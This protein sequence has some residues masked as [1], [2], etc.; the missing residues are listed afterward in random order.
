LL[1]LSSAAADTRIDAVAVSGY[2]QSREEVW[3]EPIYRNVWALLHEFGDA[4]L[5]GLVAP[6]ALVVEAARG[7]E[8]PDPP[9]ATGSVRDGRLV[10]AARGRL[11][12][13]PLAQTRD[14][15]DR[16][17][18][19]FRELGAAAKLSL[20]VSGDGHGDPGSAPA[21]IAFLAALGHKGSLRDLGGA[22]HDGRQGFDAGVRLHRQF[23]QLVDF[24]QGLL[25]NAPEVRQQ[26]W[27]KANTVHLRIRM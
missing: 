26:F 20:V 18:P 19:I 3:R 16:A 24:T 22:P 11:T 13:P 7:P 12:S 4:E 2:F 25:R 9:Q 8:V 17:R 6:R 27:S 1:A 10:T 5:A 21:L 23:Q 14:E 15:I